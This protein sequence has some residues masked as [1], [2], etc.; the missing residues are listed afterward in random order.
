MKL[1]LL[2]F[3]SYN[4]AAVVTRDINICIFQWSLATPM[5]GSFGFLRNDSP[6]VEN[7]LI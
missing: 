5:K 7:L 2:L 4:F 6:Q 1:L 3:Q